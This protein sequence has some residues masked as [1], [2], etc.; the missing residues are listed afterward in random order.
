MRT[1]RALAQQRYAL[2]LSYITF[3]VRQHPNAGP[4]S[5][6]AHKQQQH[7]NSRRCGFLAA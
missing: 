2:Y 3:S 4:S 6:G 1:L 5:T 7:L